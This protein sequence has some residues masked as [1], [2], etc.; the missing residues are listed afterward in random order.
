[1]Q[2][3]SEQE[4]WNAEVYLY[5]VFN[6]IWIK[7]TVFMGCEICV[8]RGLTFHMGVFYGA[9]LGTWVCMEFGKSK[10]GGPRTNPLHVL[11]Y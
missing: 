7:N 2:Q 4:V 10:V 8:F 3:T 11:S 6:W 5:V 9:N 1:M